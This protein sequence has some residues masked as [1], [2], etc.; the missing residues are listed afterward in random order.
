MSNH[1]GLISNLNFGAGTGNTI[2]QAMGYFI[3]LAV[4]IAVIYYLYRWMQYRYTIKIFE[5]TAGGWMMTKDT[6]REVKDANDK[7]IVGHE[8]KKNK[9]SWSGP[10]NRDYFI[11]VKKAFGF[12]YE[13]YMI[14]DKENNLSCV[15]PP[16]DDYKK[17][18]GIT[19]ADKQHAQLALKKSMERYTQSDWWDK[20]GN[21]V[22]QIA[23]IS[24]LL[25]FMIVIVR[26]LGVFIDAVGAQASSLQQAVNSLNTQ[27]ISNVGNTTGVIT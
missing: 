27:T 2:M 17:F 13:V 25:V 12:G 4:I 15:E 11:P 9:D 6:A 1:E 8:L 20:Y 21:T 23:A 22:L 16:I 26:E 24:I 7:S 5:K 10:I 19:S 14:K 3:V 18:H